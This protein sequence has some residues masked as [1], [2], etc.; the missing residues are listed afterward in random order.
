MFDEKR[1]A[2]QHLNL[3]SKPLKSWTVGNPGLNSATI[4]SS[5]LLI[6]RNI[7]ISDVQKLLLVRTSK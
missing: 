5:D 4:K 1:D 7:L 6:N 2:G 3:P